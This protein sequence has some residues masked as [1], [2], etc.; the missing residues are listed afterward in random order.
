[1]TLYVNRNNKVNPMRNKNVLGSLL[2]KFFM[3]LNIF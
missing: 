1:M 3:D 2:V